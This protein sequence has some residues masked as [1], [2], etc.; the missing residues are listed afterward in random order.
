M[1]DWRSSDEN[2]ATQSQEGS[3]AM[4][5]ASA[6]CRASTVDDDSAV[7]SAFGPKPTAGVTVVAGGGTGTGT[8][9]AAGSGSALPQ[10]PPQPTPGGVGSGG[11]AG[12]ARAKR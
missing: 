6:A 3:C 10:P 11:G 4:H 1:I 7:A 8:G 9:A 12:C 5:T 2:V